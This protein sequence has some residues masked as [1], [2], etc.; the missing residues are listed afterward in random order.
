MSESDKPRREHEILRNR[1]SWLSEA[2]L[3]IS[4]SLDLDSVLREVVDMAGT[5]TGA[6]YACLITLNEAGEVEEFLTSGS[7]PEERQGLLDLPERARLHEYFRDLP[8]PLA[9]ENVPAHLESLGFAGDI[10]TYKTFLGTPMRYQG[11]HV[12]N[13]YLAEKDAGRAFTREDQE[14]LAM[15]AAQAA[16]AIANGGRYRDERRA[17]A[18]LEALIDTSPVG[19]VVFDARSGAAL[20]LNRETRRILERLRIPGRSLNELL[21][22]VSIERAD[23][24][25]FSLDEFPAEGVPRESASVRAEEIV[26]RVPDGRSVTTLVNATP[27]VSDGGEVESVVVT[28]QDMAPMVELDRMRAKFLGM[29]S[30]ELRAPLASVRGSATT[31]LDA[32]AGL[33]PAEMI[34]FFRI[35]KEQADH[36]RSLIGDLLD[37]GRIAAGTLSVSPEPA[38]VTGLVDQARSTFLSGGG[39]NPLEIDLPMDLPQVLADR[40]R[41][42]QVLGN[43]LANAAR[44]SP[45]PSPIRIEA[46]RQDVHVAVSVADEGTGV[47]AELLPHLFRKVARTGGAESEEEPGRAGLGLAISKGLV[48]AHG[49]RIWAESEGPGRGNPVHVHA[50]GCRGGRGQDQLGRAVGGPGGS[51]REAE[52]RAGGG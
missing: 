31:V 29:V 47:P 30:H 41:I 8:E 22:V 10:L 6:R 13:F 43:L 16:A 48:E 32:E 33:D 39:R 12:G 35:I 28:L 51:G 40:R 49:G 50:P 4:Q 26:I 36:M 38:T 27:I 17:R 3:R 23:G 44:H 19:V 25:Q 42:V 52:V 15:F 7:S 2:S 5:L 11:A 14:V 20:S 21:K 34:Q 24:R 46:A 37:A 9:I 45:R 1:L 18:D